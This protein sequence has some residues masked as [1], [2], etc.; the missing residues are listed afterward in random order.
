VSDEWWTPWNIVQPLADEFANGE[1]DL[2]PCCTPESAKGRVYYTIADDGLSLPWN[3]T[4]WLN[5][6]YSK[7]QPWIEKSLAEIQAGNARLVVAMLPVLG[8]NRWFAMATREASLIRFYPKRINFYGPHMSE[9][10]NTNSVGNVV[11]VFGKPSG[12]HGTVAHT[13]VTCN[14]TFWPARNDA[15]TCSPA[16]RMA[17]SRQKTD[18]IRSYRLPTL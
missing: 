18:L 3:G 5:P 6:P 12:R 1:F 4:V 15:K 2:D 13:C 16:C 9:R 7:I 10:G 8:G 14:T 11:M 17:L